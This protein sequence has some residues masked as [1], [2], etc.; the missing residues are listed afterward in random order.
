MG[1]LLIADFFSLTNSKNPVNFNTANPLPIVE[2]QRKSLFARADLG[3]KN[4]LFVEGSFRRDYS[5]TEAPGYGINTSSVGASF[6]FSDLIN[7]N[8]A[9]FYFFVW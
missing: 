7:K 4:F 5:S 1:G 6:V 8:A 3:F 9:K 2:R